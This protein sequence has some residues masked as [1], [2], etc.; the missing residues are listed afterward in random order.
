MQH[1]PFTPQECDKI[2]QWLKQ[3]GIDFQILKDEESEKAFRANDGQN[4]VQRAEFRTETFLAQL[5]YVEIPSMSPFEQNEFTRQFLPPEE[6]LPASL[7][8]RP[9]RDFLLHQDA[10]RSTRQKRYWARILA[11]AWIILLIVSVYQYIK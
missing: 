2:V 6:K 3:R 4:V 7:D 1:G 10:Q 8:V 11:A 9:E 5:F